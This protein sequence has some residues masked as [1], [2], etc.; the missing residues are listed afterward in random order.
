MC[1][2]DCD[3]ECSDGM[4]CGSPMGVLTCSLQLYLLVSCASRRDEVCGCELNSG[5]LGERQEL[6]VALANDILGVTNNGSLYKLF[7]NV[8]HER[9]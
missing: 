4:L 8:I 3:C 6:W 5:M 1:D 7:K 2:C 9:C